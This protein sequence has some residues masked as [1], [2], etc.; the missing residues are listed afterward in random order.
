MN[1]KSP[2]LMLACLSAT[3]LAS[4]N[5]PQLA[6]Q[7]G[8][9]SAQDG[10]RPAASAAASGAPANAPVAAPANATTG[11][12]AQAKVAAGAAPSTAFQGAAALQPLPPIKA[13]VI[14]NGSLNV[15]VDDPE[16]SLSQVDQLVKIEQ[17]TILNQTIRTQ[18]EKTYVNL[19]IQ[20]PPDNFEDALGKLRDLRSHGSRV[21]VDTVSG[22]DVTD[23]FIDLDAQYRNLQATRDAYQKLLDLATSV[24]DI[25]TLTREVGNLQTQ[26]DQIKARQNLLSRQ[27]GVST[28]ALTLTP[29]GA[30]SGP[31]PLPRPM[32]AASAAWH[33]L[34]TALQG[35][36]VVLIWAAILLPLPALVLF[37]GWM[38]YRRAARLPQPGSARS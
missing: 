36:A 10:A 28:I 25:I 35:F 32:Q 6:A 30:P 4:C 8:T 15:M 14:K 21:L 16:N 7:I 29:L 26:M 34:F 17:G 24:Q 11:G 27:S 2:T 37:G 33:A 9:D 18:D 1:L 22:Q 38:L 3:L 5:G 13:M 19:T 20:V 23:Q 31:R 12:A